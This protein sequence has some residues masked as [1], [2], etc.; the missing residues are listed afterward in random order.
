MSVE[1]LDPK[2]PKGHL[3]HR[4]TQDRKVKE[5]HRETPV[6]RVY[7]VYRVYKVFKA[8]RVLRDLQDLQDLWAQ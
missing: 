2:V 3:D 1:I 8:I 4:E 7:R 6:Y 5:G